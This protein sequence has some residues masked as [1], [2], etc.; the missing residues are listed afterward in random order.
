M[1]YAN[2][3]VLSA[4]AL[5]AALIVLSTAFGVGKIA[6]HA[7]ESMARQPEAASQIRI[8]MLLAATF[9]EGIAIFG[10]VICLIVV[11]KINIT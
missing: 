7:V 2:G 6:K 1:E 9:I 10:T 11:G 3:I 4:A 5:S 8:S